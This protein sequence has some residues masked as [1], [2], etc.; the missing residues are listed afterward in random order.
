MTEGR[1]EG[2]TEGMPCFHARPLGA[3]NRQQEPSVMQGQVVFAT[4]EYF[5]PA[6]AAFSQ[7]V[8]RHVV[9]SQFC[10]NLAGDEF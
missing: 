1:D 9:L 8:R 3:G 7:N 6:P 4:S 5:V 2:H 10:V